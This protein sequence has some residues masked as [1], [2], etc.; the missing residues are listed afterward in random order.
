MI[1]QRQQ[2]VLWAVA[3][4]EAAHAHSA[5]WCGPPPGVCHEPRVLL[6][7]MPGQLLTRMHDKCLRALPTAHFGL[8]GEKR[9]KG[10]GR[11]EGRKEGGCA[12]LAPLGAHAAGRDVTT[13]TKTASSPVPYGA[14]CPWAA[15]PRCNGAPAHCTG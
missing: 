5:V 7:C 1:E 9:G 4:P 10:G 2:Q 13:T 15:L 8:G 11:G 12:F 3:A 14:S 6:Y